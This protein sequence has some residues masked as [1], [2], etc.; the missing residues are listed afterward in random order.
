MA[1]TYSRQAKSC[2]TYHCIT[3]SKVEP[4]GEED[5]AAQGASNDREGA[6]V[7]VDGKQADGGSG[8]LEADAKGDAGEGVERRSSRE[9][10]RERKSDR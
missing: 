1:A 5:R 9:R 2:L 4:D 6:D 7:A 3:C 10:D 8:G